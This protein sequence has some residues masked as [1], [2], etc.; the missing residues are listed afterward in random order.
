VSYPKKKKK[1]E[2]NSREQLIIRRETA[3]R[4]DREVRMKLFGYA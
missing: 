2:V 1:I 4:Y 3:K